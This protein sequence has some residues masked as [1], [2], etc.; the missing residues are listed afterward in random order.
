M[1]L[2]IGATL[3]GDLT[4]DHRDFAAAFPRDAKTFVRSLAKVLEIS[5]DAVAMRPL[6]TGPAFEATLDGM[7][8]VLVHR[9]AYA[10]LDALPHAMTIRFPDARFATMY[11]QL[12][13]V[14]RLRS[15]R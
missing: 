12:Q 8:I 1:T 11:G 13:L 9:K 14:N 15:R 7:T 5:A 6:E 10:K 3:R 2:M 4:P